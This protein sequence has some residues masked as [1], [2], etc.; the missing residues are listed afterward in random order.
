MD[1][2]N[3]VVGTALSFNWFVLVPMIVVLLALVYAIFCTVCEFFGD[4]IKKFGLLLF[5]LNTSPEDR[6]RHYKR[7]RKNNSEYS[8]LFART[9]YLREINPMT[10]IA[11]IF[12]LPSHL[13]D[14]LIW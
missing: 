11:D 13:F 1:Y 12:S 3:Q 5:V 14:G 8:A 10:K 9:D 2:L 7:W 6:Y 4:L